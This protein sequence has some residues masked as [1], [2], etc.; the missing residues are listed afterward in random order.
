MRTAADEAV[1]PKYSAIERER[2]FLVDPAR[3]PALAGLPHVLIEDRYLTGTRM[4]LR[5]M[6][7]SAT[8]EVALKFAKK[9]ES[10]DP[11]ARPMVNAYLDAAEYAALA[12]LPSRTLSKRRY[13]LV[14]DRGTIAVDQ[15]LGALAGLELAEFDAATDA[16]LR[17]FVP[18]AWAARDV[19][20]DPF[21]Q[22]G[23]L[24]TLGAA[25][26]RERLGDR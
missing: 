11:L 23:H 7:D 4:R 20:H 2:R 15:F 21:F 24:A 6:T 14:V 16:A 10:D 22:G 1:S 18:P 19:S 9:Y 8:G 13:Q 26:L 12:L 5:R 3:R 25:A 17:V